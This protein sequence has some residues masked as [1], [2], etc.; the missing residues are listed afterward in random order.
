[1]ESYRT[2]PT[3]QK[4]KEDDWAV[5]G[6]W[7]LCIGYSTQPIPTPLILPQLYHIRY[8]PLL[9]N[10]GPDVVLLLSPLTWVWLSYLFYEWMNFWFLMLRVLQAEMKFE[11]DEIRRD[12]SNRIETKT[13]VGEMQE[14]NAVVFHIRICFTTSSWLIMMIQRPTKYSSI[15]QTWTLLVFCWYRPMYNAS[16]MVMLVLKTKESREMVEAMASR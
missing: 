16:C 8:S 13:V 14:C 5:L 4:Q 12:E 6:A 9:P 11:R 3:M 2:V 10:D 1:M 15:I 7:M